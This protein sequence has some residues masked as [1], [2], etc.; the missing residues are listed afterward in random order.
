MLQYSRNDAREREPGP[1]ERVDEPRFLTR[2][3]T[4]PDVRASRLE[5]R[6]RAAGRHLEPFPDTGGPDLQVITTRRAETRVAGGEEHAPMREPQPLEQDFG[7][8][9]QALV[10]F[11]ALLRGAVAHHLDLVE[12]MDA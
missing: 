4:V 7:V 9:R 11:I 6:E 10:L 1:V 2:S 12:F 5:I 8:P 3:R